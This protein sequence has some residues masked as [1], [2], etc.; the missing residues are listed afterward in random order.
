M[1]PSVC[2][3]GAFKDDQ[4]SWTHRHWQN[5]SLRVIALALSRHDV[6]PQSTSQ[7][8]DTFILWYFPR[9]KYS[10]PVEDTDA[11]VYVV[12]VVCNP[13][14]A[15][16]NLMFQELAERNGTLQQ[17]ILSFRALNT[18]NN[19]KKKVNP[20]ELF[21]QANYRAWMM[22]YEHISVTLESLL[23]RKME[24]KVQAE[25]MGTGMYSLLPLMSF[26]EAKWGNQTGWWGRCS[27]K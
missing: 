27:Q 18:N 9:G 20:L 22:N 12:C 7:V 24:V 25:M 14:L 17:C 26:P 4:I 15:G 10:F 1:I 11:N 6:W 2:R 21:L 23:R 16:S 8:L 19:L 5:V 3:G 13:E